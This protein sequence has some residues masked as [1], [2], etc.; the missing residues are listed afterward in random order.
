[1]TSFRAVKQR[2]YGQLTA[3]SWRDTVYDMITTPVMAQAIINPLL[4]LLPRPETKWQAAVCFGKAVARIT[5]EKKENGRN[6][7]RRLMWSL[8]EDSGNIGWGVAPAM[9]CCI[10]ENRILGKEFNRILVSY[11]IDSGK[12]DNFLE[13]PPLRLDAYWGVGH[14][15]FCAPYEEFCRYAFPWLIKALFDVD[16]TCRLMCLWATANVVASA[17][18]NK[19]IL[20]PTDKKMLLK[21]VEKLPFI[22]VPDNNIVLFENKT[23]RSLSTLEIWHRLEQGLLSLKSTTSYSQ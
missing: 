16:D 19:S 13:Y 7:M 1:M 10:G 22:K 15:C 20:K 14:A 18:Q 2:L 3:T 21:L 17:C 23:I 9:A 12:A 6:I 5:E 8:N 11:I 4:S